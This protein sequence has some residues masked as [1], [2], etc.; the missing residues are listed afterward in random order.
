M[1][2]CLSPGN[3]GDAPWGRELLFRMGKLPGSCRLLMDSAYEGDETRALAAELGF[4]PVVPP[5]PKRKNPW[6]LDEYWYKRRNE[7]E[8]LIR[9]IKGYR[10]IFTRYDKLDVMF[11]GFIVFA[12]IIEYL[13]LC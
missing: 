4:I 12:F 10:R 13:K 9:R 6:K 7:V 2:F 3:E 8:R 1:N 5:N 11:H